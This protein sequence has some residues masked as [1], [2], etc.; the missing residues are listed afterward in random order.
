MSGLVMRPRTLALLVGVG[1]GLLA[2]ANTHLVY[3]AIMSQP[4]CVA[5]QKA[6]SSEPGTYRAAGSAC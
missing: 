1:L 3:V 2:L 4:D 5:H 6:A